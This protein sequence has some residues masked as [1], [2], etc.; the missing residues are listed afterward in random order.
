M[1]PIIGVEAY[2]APGSRF[3]RNPGEDEEKYHHL[4]LL[5]RN[6]TGYRNLLKLVS[7]PTSRASTTVP[8]WTSS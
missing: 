8:A 5:A 1:K 4:T 7:P 2:V 3:D 6:E